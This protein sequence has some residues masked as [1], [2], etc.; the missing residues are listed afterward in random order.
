[1]NVGKNAVYGIICCII[2]APRYNV[3]GSRQPAKQECDMNTRYT[4]RRDFAMRA[5][6]N[7]EIHL[8]TRLHIGNTFRVQ[9][10]GSISGLTTF[11]VDF[12]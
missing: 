11:C 3:S 12:A 2:A 8:R 9:S 7:P 6:Q 10:I 1:M 4:R 5:P